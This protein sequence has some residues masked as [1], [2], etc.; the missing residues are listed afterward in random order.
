MSNVINW[1]EIPVTD[2]DRAISFYSTL[3]GKSIEKA[4]FGPMPYAFLPMEGDGVGGALAQGEGYVP[5]T[6]GV[7]VYLSGGD[8]LSGILSKV[9]AAGGSIQVPKTEIGGEMGYFAHFLDS[10]GNKIGVH[11]MH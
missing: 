8:D 11:S 6:Q 4:K 7:T 9:E 2:I 3:L 5:S 10:E 1:F